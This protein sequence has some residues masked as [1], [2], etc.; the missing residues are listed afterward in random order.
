MKNDETHA[1]LD[2]LLSVAGGD[3]DLSK[4]LAPHIAACGTCRDYLAWLRGFNEA[5]GEEILASR[6][7][8]PSPDELA[9]ISPGGDTEHAHV[10]SCPLCQEELDALWSLQRDRASEFEIDGST[11]IPP[12]LLVDV[13]AAV[14][15]SGA[16]PLRLELTE[17]AEL[18]APVA[19]V[20]VS[21][22]VH[23][24]MIVT[25]LS[26][27]PEHPVYLVLSDEVLDKRT[28]LTT[29]ECREPVGSWTRARIEEEA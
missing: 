19:G 24:G 2:D 29:S 17:G 13:P 14:Y 7:G 16:I 28:A 3:L 5:L 6:P 26:A 22:Q 11:F 18:D 27:E 10:G 9:T 20:E 8:C 1:S 25:K 4:S 12:P 23:E 15:R 21:L